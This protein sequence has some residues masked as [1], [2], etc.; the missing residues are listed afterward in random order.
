MKIQITDLLE[1][2]NIETIDLASYDLESDEDIELMK[3]DLAN[4]ILSY[5]EENI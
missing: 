5:V 4:I 2:Y 1:E 3:N